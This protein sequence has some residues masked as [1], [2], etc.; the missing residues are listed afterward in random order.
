[1][2]AC[3]WHATWGKEGDAR[4]GS[5]GSSVPPRPFVGTPMALSALYRERLYSASRGLVA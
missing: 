1:M 2:R 4:F 5:G 3:L